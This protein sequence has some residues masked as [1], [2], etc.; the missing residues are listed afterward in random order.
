MIKRWEVP[1]LNIGKGRGF[2]AK[3]PF[4]LPLSTGKQGRSQAA[5]AAAWGGGERRRG[6]CG[7]DSRSL[8]GPGQPE[9]ARP[10]RPAAAAMAALDWYSRGAA[11]VK[12]RGRSTSGP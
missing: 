6:L 2:W 8:P 11:A 4:L 5:P 7:V 3:W 10:L 1:L 12:R 9:M